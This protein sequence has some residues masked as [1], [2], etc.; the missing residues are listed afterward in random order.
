MQNGYKPTNMIQKLFAE[1]AYNM[2]LKLQ[3]NI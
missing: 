2:L 1:A 3:I